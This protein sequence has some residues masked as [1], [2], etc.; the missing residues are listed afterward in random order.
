M[1]RILQR[2]NVLNKENPYTTNIPAKTPADDPQPE[3]RIAQVTAALSNLKQG[4][5]AGPAEIII[6]NGTGTRKRK[7]LYRISYIE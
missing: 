7:G 6:R 2:L 4:K 5:A 3:I 1:E